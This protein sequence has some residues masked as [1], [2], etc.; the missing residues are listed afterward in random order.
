MERSVDSSSDRVRPE[1][2]IRPLLLGHSDVASTQEPAIQFTMVNA[3]LVR[4]RSIT[5]SQGF[6]TGSN[7]CFEDCNGRRRHNLTFAFSMNYES[8]A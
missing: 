4:L 7:E 3:L 1:A 8:K 6:G 2:V 5:N